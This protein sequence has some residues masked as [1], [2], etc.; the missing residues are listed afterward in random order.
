MGKAEVIPLLPNGSWPCELSPATK[1]T[2]GKAAILTDTTRA[3]SKEGPCSSCLEQ[4]PVWEKSTRRKLAAVEELKTLAA[5]SCRWL[6]KAHPPKKW[7]TMQKE[8]ESQKQ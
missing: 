2:Q 4:A 1:S 6:L 8:W 7:P 3:L 5:G